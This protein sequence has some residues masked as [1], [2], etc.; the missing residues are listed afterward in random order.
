MGG[1]MYKC[2]MCLEKHERTRHIELYVWGSEGVNLCH[3][4]EMEVNKYISQS[5]IVALRKK[6]DAA[7]K[8]KG[9]YHV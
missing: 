3:D 7:L 5:A 4:C 9:E 6:R 1:Q 2:D 8:K